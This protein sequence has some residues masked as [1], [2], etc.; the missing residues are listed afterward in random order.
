M[1][2]L[3]LQAPHHGNLGP[4]DVW[5]S[6][7][8][9]HAQTDFPALYP[10]AGFPPLETH[11]VFLDIRSQQGAGMIKLIFTILPKVAAALQE[12]RQVFYLYFTASYTSSFQTLLFPSQATHFW[13]MYGKQLLLLSYHSLLF[14]L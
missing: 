7:R 3:N 6:C 14:Y 11:N 13:C 1:M 5:L 9:F 12:Q 10:T 8:L 4:S 2:Y